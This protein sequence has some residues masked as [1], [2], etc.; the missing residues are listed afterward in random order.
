MKTHHWA[1]AT[2]AMKNLF[3]LVPGGVYGWPKNVLHWAGIPESI[4]DLHHLFP[5]QFTIVDGIVGME[6]N[7]PIQGTPKNA[8][9]L[10]AGSD[11]A[12][13]DATC[14]RIMG[15]DP[16]KI[17]YLAIARGP[18]NLNESN[19]HQTGESILS[20]KTNFELLD[21]WKEIRA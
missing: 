10:V 16:C 7:G 20:V 3:G 12:A 18:E 21:V 11:V 14:C 9:V 17:E 13:V 19:F 4:V 2:L 6:G 1:G 5:R 15:I 8:G